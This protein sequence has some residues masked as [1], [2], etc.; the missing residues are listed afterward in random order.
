MH[1]ALISP[2]LPSHLSTHLVLGEALVALGHRVTLLHQVEVG[3]R[4]ASGSRR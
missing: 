2:P 4:R 1:V 3:C